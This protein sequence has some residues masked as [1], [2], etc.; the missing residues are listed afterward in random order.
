MRLATVGFAK[1]NKRFPLN[2]MLKLPSMTPKIKKPALTRIRILPSPRKKLRLLAV[3]R[4]HFKLFDLFPPRKPRF[5]NLKRRRRGRGR[6]RKPLPWGR[7]PKSLRLDPPP[8]SPERLRYQHLTNRLF[9][10]EAFLRRR[11][12]YRD[13]RRAFVQSLVKLPKEARP[14]SSLNDF[15]FTQRNSSL[16][17]PST[18][19]SLRLGG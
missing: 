7:L 18:L 5:L 3:S 19:S 13:F 8:L 17:S 6:G 14:P 4:P 9:S 11:K 15:V 16:P 2:L 10:R 1:T 12:Y